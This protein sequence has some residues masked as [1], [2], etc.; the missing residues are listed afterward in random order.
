[1]TV[2]R[3]TC[4]APYDGSIAI[5]HMMDAAH[6]LGLGSCWVNTAQVETTSP[7]SVVKSICREAGLRLPVVG[8]GYLALG[9]PS[10]GFAHDVKKRVT[11]RSFVL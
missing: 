5:S 8:V 2:A 4:F 6:A 3:D 9:C 11:G 1:M 7:D 10:G